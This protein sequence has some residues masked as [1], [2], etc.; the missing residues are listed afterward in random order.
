[1]PRG[2]EYEEILNTDADCYAG[3]GFGNGGRVMA[4]ERSSHGRPFTLNLNVPP[5]G[6]LILKPIALPVVECVE[7]AAEAAPEDTSP[8]EES[9]VSESVAEEA[10]PNATE[11]GSGR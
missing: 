11:Q 9:V 8:V 5:L 4:E 10:T 1:M 2:G 6:A 3:S 7:P